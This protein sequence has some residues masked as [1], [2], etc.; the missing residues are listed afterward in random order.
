MEKRSVRESQE[1]QLQHLR[2]FEWGMCQ[3]TVLKNL[4]WK[5]RGMCLFRGY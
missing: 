3:T 2:I 5:I 4:L 1:T